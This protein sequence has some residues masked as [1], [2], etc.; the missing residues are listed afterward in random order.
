[1]R[2]SAQK[3]ATPWKTLMEP[4]NFALVNHLDGKVGTPFYIMRPDIYEKNLVSFLQAFKQRY[5]K[6]IAGYSFKTN[7]VPALC[8]RAKSLG[9]YA[10]VVSEMEM[11]IAKRIG[12]DH[13]IFNGPIKTER[14]LFSALEDGVIINLDSGYEIDSILKYRK[15]NPHKDIS[16]GLRINVKLTDANGESMIQCGLRSGRF[17]FTIESLLKTI[18]ALLEAKVKIVSIHG[19]TSSSDRAVAN[20]AI[21]TERMLE[22]CKSFHLDDVVYFDVGGG[23]FGA[24]AEGIDVSNKPKYEDY[25]NCIL[26]VCMNDGWFMKNKPSI[27]IE[28]GASVVSNVFSYVMRVYQNKQINGTHFVTVDGSVFDVKPTM[29][30]YN[31]PFDTFRKEDIM[32]TYVCDVVGSTCMEK[33]VILKG[34]EMPVV[35]QNDYIVMRGVGAYTISLTP[36]FI[37]Y[38]SPI[39]SIEDNVATCVRRR[40]TVEDV[41]EIYKW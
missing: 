31:L 9:C 15:E 32:E 12:F 1:M 36:T 16:V 40:Q 37:N 28:P 35:C 39:V 10:E 7:Y 17:G 5:Q 38:L 23:F 3:H 27:V 34:V 24:A 29:H 20:Y 25:A 33:D 6:I 13:I 4:I 18:P 21:I 2:V 41:L 11:Q 30:G 19:H 22:V 8:C 14:A 26:D